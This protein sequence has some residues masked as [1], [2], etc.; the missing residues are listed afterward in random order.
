MAK[1]FDV[2]GY[3][4]DLDR[5]NAEAK[6]GEFIIVHKLPDDIDVKNTI[7]VVINNDEKKK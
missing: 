1:R 2:S 7:K 4:K 6:E 3:F 5:R